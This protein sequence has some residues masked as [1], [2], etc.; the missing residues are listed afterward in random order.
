MTSYKT[1]RCYMM[2]SKYLL[3]EANQK[4]CLLIR[5][6]FRPT[7]R[8][9]KGGYFAGPILSQGARKSFGAS[10]MVPTVSH[11][12]LS[13]SRREAFCDP[14]R[15]LTFC[16]LIRIPIEHIRRQLDELQKY[17]FI[18]RYFRQPKIRQ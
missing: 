4:G 6:I 1:L 12:W 18:T 8:R 15:W 13:W 7:E 14:P 16:K 9:G 2:G 3:F 17:I 11:E 5:P 10:K